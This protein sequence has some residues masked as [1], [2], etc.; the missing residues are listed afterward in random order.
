MIQ[1]ISNIFENISDLITNQ[2]AYDCL[3]HLGD[4]HLDF[5]MNGESY[6]FAIGNMLRDT[7]GKYF[8]FQFR[9]FKVGIGESG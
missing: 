1:T 2:V 4:R 6:H 5:M 8:L 3:T 9:E 7:E